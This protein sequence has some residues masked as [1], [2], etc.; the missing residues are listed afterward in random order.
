VLGYKQL[1]DV[2]DAFR[3]L[4]TTLELRPNYHSKDERIKCHI[5]LCFIS[6]VLVRIIENQTGKTWPTVRREMS[7]LYYGEFQIDSKKVC[8]LT[9][10]TPEQKKILAAMNIKEP[11]TVVGIHDV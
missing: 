6:L 1:Y 4:K 3:T 2:D 9:E 10:L 5:F 7:R 11:S 8:Q